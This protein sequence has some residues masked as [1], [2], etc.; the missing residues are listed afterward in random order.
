M[1]A[2]RK[3]EKGSLSFMD[4]EKSKKKMMKNIHLPPIALVTSNNERVN[5]NNST[6]ETDKTYKLAPS[7]TKFKNSI[8][9]EAKKYKSVLNKSQLDL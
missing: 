5:L 3:D 8:L 9:G 2:N 1:R 7:T 4:I 6:I